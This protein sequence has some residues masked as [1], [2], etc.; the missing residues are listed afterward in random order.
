ME[1]RSRK[2]AIV[3][4]G[5]TEHLLESSVTRSSSEETLNLTVIEGDRAAGDV[6]A[7][8]P[9]VRNSIRLPGTSSLIQDVGTVEEG[10]V[11]AREPVQSLDASQK[12]IVSQG[13]GAVRDFSLGPARDLTLDQWGPPEP[14]LVLRREIS[15][16][17]LGVMGERQRP[18][19]ADISVRDPTL[20]SCRPGAQLEPGKFPPRAQ[21]LVLKKK[22]M[23]MIV[24]M[25]IFM[26]IMLFVL[27]WKM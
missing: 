20:I 3:D 15:D 24:M 11:S 6:G 23:K 13:V 14:T 26:M 1:T 4:P 9:E 16:P 19:L 27:K 17:T 25:V 12:V 10:Q 21:K 18:S 2:R 8:H 22:C 7:S 5:P